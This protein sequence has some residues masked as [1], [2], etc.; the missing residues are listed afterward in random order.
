VAASLAM[1]T[2]QSSIAIEVRKKNPTRGNRPALCANHAPQHTVRNMTNSPTTPSLVAHYSNDFNEE[3]LPSHG[4]GSALG[5]WM[6]LALVATDAQGPAREEIERVLRTDAGDAAR[7]VRVLLDTPHPALHAALALWYEEDFM[8]ERFSAFADSLPNS[9]TRG[10][11]PTQDAADAWANEHS[12]GLVPKFPLDIQSRTAIVLAS[13]LATRGDWQE[14]FTDS[15]PEAL[16]G[17]FASQTTSALRSP[18]SHNVFVVR[19]DAAGHVGAHTALTRDGLLVVSVIGD[20]EAPPA[21]MHRAATEVASM[22]EGGQAST[23]QVSLFD[24]P[25]GEGGSW[26]IEEH[27]YESFGPPTIETTEAILAPWEISTLSDLVNAPGVSSAFDTMDKWI[28]PVLRPGSFQAKQAAIA[29]FTKTGFEAAA[30][31]AMSA[32]AGSVPQRT[33]TTERKLTLRF[34]RPYAVVAL[35]Q[36]S[37]P[38]PAAP[39]RQVSIA[40]TEWDGLPVFA[41]WVGHVDPA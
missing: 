24:L 9:T 41:A 29:R 30:V 28:H 36:S 11:V 32:R 12:L 19:T 37:L 14:P 27:L 17:D 13:T 22:L 5:L 16:G 23:H 15:T 7:R 20:P 2:N 34:N 31:T 39:W 4:V 8:A 33:L 6:L 3:V 21:T 26:S 1:V 40:S 35:T 10:P 18:V 25:L 38:D